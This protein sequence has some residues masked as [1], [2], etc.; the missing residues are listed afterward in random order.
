MEQVDDII[1]LSL[2]EIGCDIDESIKSL[3]SFEPELCVKAVAMLI[4]IMNPQIEIPGSLPPGMAQRFQVTTQLA[5]TCTVSIG[6]TFL[7]LKINL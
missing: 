6:E 7:W 4:K 3:S 2:R 5:E 1:I